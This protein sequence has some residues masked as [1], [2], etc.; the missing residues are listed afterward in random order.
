MIQYYDISIVLLHF[1]EVKTCRF[2]KESVSASFITIAI[3]IYYQNLERL[4]KTVEN[5]S[6]TTPTLFG[7]ELLRDHVIPSLLGPHEKE[8]LY[9]S[10]KEIA[11]KF[12]VFQTD[13]IPV[14]FSSA[15]WGELTL[16]RL[17]KDEAFYM[18]TIGIN[19]EK[20]S[21]RNY[22]LESGFIAEQYQK[23]NG[24]LTECFIK[25]KRKGTQI[26]FQVKWDLKSSI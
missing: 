10:G 22:D 15:G 3:H 13:E 5:N 4:H 19:D 21:N 23:I 17:S 8:I 14:F 7:Y 16:E 2:I 11:R 24:Y 25:P 26:E 18:L 1:Q 12:P 6:H 20:F 9:W